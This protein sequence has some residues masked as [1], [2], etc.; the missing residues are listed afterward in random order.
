MYG[1][2]LRCI[3]GCYRPICYMENPSYIQLPLRGRGRRGSSTITA[4]IERF[5]RLD[6]TTFH[7]L[8]CVRPKLPGLVPDVLLIPAGNTRNAG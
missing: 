5:I 7:P 8:P 6:K 1:I 2:M 3:A 4:G